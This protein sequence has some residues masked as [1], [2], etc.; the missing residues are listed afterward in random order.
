MEKAT[1]GYIFGWITRLL[2]LLFMEFPKP[3]TSWKTSCFFLNDAIFWRCFW[4]NIN[5]D[6]FDDVLQNAK[7]R[8]NDVNR[9]PLDHIEIWATMW[10]KV[11][12]QIELEPKI[13]DKC[14]PDPVKVCVLVRIAKFQSFQV[15]WQTRRLITLYSEPADP[16]M[17]RQHLILT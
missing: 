15:D 1:Q 14:G 13:C 4:K 8:A 2:P 5:V 12:N 7:H 11:S 17:M 3:K 16:E 9:P 10:K 6:V